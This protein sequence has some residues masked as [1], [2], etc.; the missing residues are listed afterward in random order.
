MISYNA[1][2]YT[3]SDEAHK[4]RQEEKERN[5]KENLILLSCLFQQK[6][7]NIVH[8]EY[9]KKKEFA[10]SEYMRINTRRRNSVHNSTREKVKYT[11]SILGF[12]EPTQIH[13]LVKYN[14]QIQSRTKKPI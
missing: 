3:F 10:P 4:R 8:S 6:I 9:I 14:K 11:R 2:D 1:M 12:E 13:N 5:H 7:K